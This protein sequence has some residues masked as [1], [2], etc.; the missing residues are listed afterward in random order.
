VRFYLGTRAVLLG[1]RRRPRLPTLNPINPNWDSV[2]E[3]QFGRGSRST[4][5][6]ANA[7]KPALV[8]E[9]EDQE[10]LPRFRGPVHLDRLA[11]FMLVSF[12]FPYAVVGCKLL[13]VRT[14]MSQASKSYQFLSKRRCDAASTGFVGQHQ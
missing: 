12:S 13:A 7:C 3:R 6:M 5:Q 4:D 2:F 1:G 8:R 9:R 10:S 11:Q 14:K